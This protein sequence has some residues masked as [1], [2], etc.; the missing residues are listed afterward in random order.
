MRNTLNGGI[1]IKTTILK[2][3]IKWILN[4]YYFFLIIVPLFCIGL[5]SLNPTDKDIT[6][7]PSSAIET[8]HILIKQLPIEDRLY[9]ANMDRQEVAFLNLSLGTYI[10]NTFGLWEGNV[11]LM[12]SC[13]EEADRESLHPDEASAVI[14]ARMALELKFDN[15]VLFVESE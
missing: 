13:A 12:D 6:P 9:V 1:I 4:N 14:L 5:I 2:Q 11:V 10:R 3:K 15:G 7:W 8:A